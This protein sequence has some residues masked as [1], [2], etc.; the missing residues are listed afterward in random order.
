MLL[1][2]VRGP[3]SYEDL[4]TIDGVLHPTFKAAY[5]QLGLLGDDKEWDLAINEASKGLLGCHN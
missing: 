4:Q 5:I 3:T 1:S 2:K